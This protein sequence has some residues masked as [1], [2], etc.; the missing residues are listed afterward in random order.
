M[1]V[2]VADSEVSN[3]ETNKDRLF[4]VSEDS[5]VA[6]RVATVRLYSGLRE[7]CVMWAHNMTFRPGVDTWAIDEAK[8]IRKFEIN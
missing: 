4:H 6:T 1:T 5:V 3:Y 8:R 7:L 2:G